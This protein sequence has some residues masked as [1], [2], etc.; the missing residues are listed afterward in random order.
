MSGQMAGAL[1]FATAAIIALLITGPTIWYEWKESREKRLK[2]A[3]A[4]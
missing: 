1:L 2:T 4:G 3:K